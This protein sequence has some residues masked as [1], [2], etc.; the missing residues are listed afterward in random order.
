VYHNVGLSCTDT[1]RPE[2]TISPSQF[3]RQLQ[4][5]A[6]RGYVGIKVSD[7]IAAR[8]GSRILPKKPLLITFDDAYADIGEYALP[9]LERMG[10]GATVFVITSLIG[11][12]SF[13]DG[14][15]LMNAS[16]IRHWA[17]KGVEFGS[18][19][20]T[21]PDLTCVDRAT[22]RREVVVSARALAD[23]TSIRPAAF[24]YPYGHYNEEVRECVRWTY[25][26]GLTCDVGVNDANT[27][28]Y[29]L[30]RA[31]AEPSW[32]IIDLVRLVSGRPLLLN[33]LRGRIRLR[34][35]LTTVAGACRRMWMAV[36]T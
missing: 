3:E 16:Q 13:W 23:I 6:W 15:K 5:L 33:H 25:D 36:N 7:L 17:T 10:F 11:T 19:T 9:L 32:M 12:T 34:S 24:S 14:R 28:A 30:R 26:A 4:W 21:H 18:H 20:C 27:D 1:R 8:N 2:L 35:R 29:L 31:A 22:L